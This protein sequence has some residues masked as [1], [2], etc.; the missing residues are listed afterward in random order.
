MQ[1]LYLSWPSSNQ[2][3]LLYGDVKESVILCLLRCFYLEK[4]ETF[5]QQ[6]RQYQNYRNRD[7]TS[8]EDFGDGLRCIWVIS[9]LASNLG[10]PC[11]IRLIWDNSFGL[12]P[13]KKLKTFLRRDY[14]FK[15]DHM[16]LAIMNDFSEVVEVFI[17]YTSM[18][19]CTNFKKPKL[20]DEEYSKEQ[21]QTFMEITKTF[22]ESVAQ[23][24]LSD[25]FWNCEAAIENFFTD[26][27]YH[28]SLLSQ[29]EAEIQK[30]MNVTK[31]EDET[32]ARFYLAEH[33]GNSEVAVMA[34]NVESFKSDVKVTDDSETNE[35]FFDEDADEELSEEI[36]NESNDCYENSSDNEKSSDSILKCCICEASFQDVLS[37]NEHVENIHV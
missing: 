21:V 20:E 24:F 36:S 3:H 18:T 35:D 15:T 17:E 1:F 6:Q 31:I 28:E 30:F 33:D 13:I 2:N 22:N 19:G 10:N 8:A 29:N 16:N 4:A 25:N 32:V 9:D 14:I 34:V 5:A 26:K 7:T 12:S 11:L 37:L 27:Q 23:K